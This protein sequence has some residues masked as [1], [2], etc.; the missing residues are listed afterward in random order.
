MFSAVG[1]VMGS[2]TDAKTMNGTPDFSISGRV[3]RVALEQPPPMIAK[4]FS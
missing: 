4:T 3:A 1:C 2:A